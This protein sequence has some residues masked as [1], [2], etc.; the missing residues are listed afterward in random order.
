MFLLN[1]SIFFCT[2]IFREIMNKRLRELRKTL[3]MTQA[4]FAAKLEMVQNSYSK[5]E[6]GENALTEKNI[7]LICLMYG[8]NE[9]WLR[10]GEGDMF[11]PLAKPEADDE[12]KLLELFRSLS[13]EMKAF[14]LRKVREYLRIDQEPFVSPV[15]REE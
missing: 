14:V 2:V 11:N 10:T 1:F 7:C 3:K 6:T 9:L 13:P 5:I 4:A 15:K 12:K 8:V